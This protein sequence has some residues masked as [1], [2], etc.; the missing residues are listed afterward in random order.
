MVVACGG[1]AE[2]PVPKEIAPTVAAAAR[3]PMALCTEGEP[4][5]AVGPR[6]A[7]DSYQVPM[8]PTP[9]EPP[10]FADLS[11]RLEAPAPELPAGCLAVLGS[12][13][14]AAL[15]GE[16]A[17]AM[18]VSSEDGGSVLELSHLGAR[19]HRVKGGS[20]A[21]RPL[22]GMPAGVTVDGKVLALAIEKEGIRIVRDGALPG[23]LLEKS[24]DV[25]AVELDARGTRAVAVRA[26]S[27]GRAVAI[28]WDT[29]TGRQLWSITASREADWRE[30]W[31]HAALAPD[32]WAVAI[33]SATD[34]TVRDGR[35]GKELVL[36]GARENGI[37]GI[38][39]LPDGRRI[40]VA[41]RDLRVYDLTSGRQLAEREQ[42]AADVLAVA[43][44]GG[45]I[46]TAT[47]TGQAALYS[48]AL[49]VR[50]TAS[51]FL[52]PTRL[53]FSP[54]G[55]LLA[56]SHL[57]GAVSLWQVDPPAVLSGVVGHDGTVDAVVST[58]AGLVSMDLGRV[59]RWPEP[60]G[61]RPSCLEGYEDA[62]LA[63]DGALAIAIG[64]GV[65]LYRGDAVTPVAQVDPRFGVDDVAFT[66]DGKRLLV[67]WGSSLE[68]HDA[69][70]GRRLRTVKL[71]EGGM[72]D[73][74]AATERH[75]L[76]S[77]SSDGHLYVANLSGAGPVTGP[78]AFG[79]YVSSAWAP[80]GRSAIAASYDL[81]RF[82]QSGR[83][84]AALE[85]DGT[86][87]AGVW[88]PD[89]RWF[90]F[91]SDSAV[92]AFDAA[93]NRARWTSKE[94]AAPIAVVDRGLIAAVD[95]EQ[96]GT[97]ILLDARTGERRGTL[98]GGELA[99]WIKQLV[100]LPQRR[101]AAAAYE[102]RILLWK[103]P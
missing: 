102:G 77:R 75:A 88:S 60:L 45:L 30:G 66:R 80:D 22:A 5:C 39:F 7:P 86:V 9:A 24:T 56:A 57:G 78:L 101:L 79:G 10:R 51:L 21:P 99:G 49:A 69:E 64:A 6:P 23:V 58:G 11:P 4:D 12:P 82:D 52:S 14:R 71:T 97:I 27:R 85:L 8:T 18:A 17:F 50:D 55:K 44:T 59:C 15:H 41:G 38:E 76:L 33:A 2:R 31:R 93:D 89:G 74:H 43:P 72:A 95:R 62:A 13:P 90:A 53:A 94:A 68:V 54:D 91:A 19:R 25:F 65:W 98:A 26:Q 37:T 103:V 1:E 83:V 3:R 20:E 92:T 96:Q 35:D 67:L 81:H 29:A 28:A 48:P 87:R 61:S 100:A 73:L 63:P 32:G 34:V 84:L 36:L 46:A 40:A 47:G 42:V 16:T 70:S